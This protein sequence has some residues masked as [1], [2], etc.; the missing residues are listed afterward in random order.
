[1][2]ND[3]PEKNLK[4]LIHKCVCVFVIVE[5]RKEM[6]QLR[7]V[8]LSFLPEERRKR[9]RGLNREEKGKGLVSW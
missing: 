1:M 2:K 6:D 3:D 4:F 9:K 5:R 8:F 7:G